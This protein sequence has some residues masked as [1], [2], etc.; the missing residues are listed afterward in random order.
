MDLEEG[1]VSASKVGRSLD[2]D[3]ATAVAP[4]PSPSHHTWR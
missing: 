1:T 3:L 2:P 4:G